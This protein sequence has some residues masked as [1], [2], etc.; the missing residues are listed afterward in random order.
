[1][2]GDRTQQ[3]DPA[4]E[5]PEAA[6]AVRP[7]RPDEVRS[8]LMSR[9][10]PGIDKIRQIATTLGL[11]PY[12]VFMV[13]MLWS[14]DR[15]GEGHPQEISRHEILPTPRIR[16]MSATSE[17]LSSFGR[18]EE[19]SIVVDRISA[20]YSEDDLMGVT[21][22][23]IDPTLQRT[24]KRNGEYFWEVQENR[25]GC[26]NP[27]P[28]RYVPSGTPTLMRGGLHWRVPLAKQMVNRSRNQTMDR[29]SQ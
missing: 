17:V 2:A 18:I 9:L 26:P 15:I 22:D 11:R 13:H 29:R 1:M 28:R 21:P 12:R 25:P 4:A 19:G 24:G 7:L 23:L 6:G 20:K 14:G 5:I 3:N 16:D 27:I 10:V 8:S